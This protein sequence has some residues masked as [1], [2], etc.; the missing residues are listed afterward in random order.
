MDPT[1]T[2]PQTKEQYAYSALRQAII[3]CELVPGEKLVIDRLSEEMGVSQI[4]I[5][6]AIQRLQTEGFVHINPHA[7]ATVAP[8]PP[9]KIVEIF[10]LL[11]SLERTAFRV[12][13]Q[14]ASAEQVNSLDALVHQMD[15]ALVEEDPNRWL[16]LNT[17]FHR[18]IAEMAGMPL[19]QD[20]TSRVLDE[21]ERA[22]HFYFRYVTSGRLPR[23]QSEHHQIIALLRAVDL[24]ALDALAVTHNREALR[25][26]QAILN[27]P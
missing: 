2:T 16:Q 13:A 3:R 9:E 19:L 25:A 7:S 6:S 23:A 14:K 11:E 27:A 26:Y 15:A 21:W 8:L 12:V 20:F 17:D 4:P 1:P 5:R 10:A 22:S 24:E 18:N